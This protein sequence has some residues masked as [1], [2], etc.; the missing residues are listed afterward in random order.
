VIIITVTVLC[1]NFIFESFAVLCEKRV[2]ANQGEDST[3]I[4]MV[5]AFNADFVGFSIPNK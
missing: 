1:I 2:V 5:P 4:A 3:A